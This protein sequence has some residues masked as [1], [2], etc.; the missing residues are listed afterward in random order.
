MNI[1]KV[2][3]RARKVGNIGEDAAAAL[4]RLKKYKIV[5]R[6]YA[7]PQSEIDIIAE[8]RDYT[9]FVEV[10]A[11]SYGDGGT[12]WESRPAAAVTT[13]K[14]AAII[15]AAKCYLSY[16][17]QDKRVRFD[18]VEVYLDGDRIKRTVH[19]ENAFRQEKKGKK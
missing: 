18:V 6:N 10:K 9:V 5:E 1:L 7:G 12:S 13:E 15:K 4:L 17:K 8:N 14:Q 2:L 11:R 3:T 16:N 19:I